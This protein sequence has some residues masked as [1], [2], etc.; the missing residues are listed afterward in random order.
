M[1]YQMHFDPYL[2]EH[3]Y[4]RHEELLQEMEVLRLKKRLRQNRRGQASRFTALLRRTHR[5]VG[6]SLQ[7]S[8][9]PCAGR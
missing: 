8:P 4:H 1:N 9:S 6:Q 7:G 5:C 3:L 2:I